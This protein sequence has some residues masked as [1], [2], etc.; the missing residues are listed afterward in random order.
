MK[1]QNCLILLVILIIC[2]FLI[3]GCVQKAEPVNC[4]DNNT[5]STCI[6]NTNEARVETARTGESSEYVCKIAECVKDTDCEN[7][8][9]QG[10]ACYKTDN[11]NS[12]NGWCAFG[13]NT[14][15]GITKDY[16]LGEID[17]ANYCDIDKDCTDVGGH[18][19]FGCNIFVNK[20]EAEGITNLMISYSQS[21]AIN[22]C[23][24]SP[25]AECINSKC[26]QSTQEPLSESRCNELCM[27]K[28][29]D[30]YGDCAYDSLDLNAERIG[31]CSSCSDCG[32]YCR[33]PVPT[34]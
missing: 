25:G 24:V 12:N 11:V 8:Y 9:G 29:G 14:Q 2:I 30:Y 19:P 3:D 31:S 13:L 7:K 23:G 20:L 33:L 28:G 4:H 6:C 1:E 10:Y 26:N 32:C 16:V 22:M 21:N 17:K 18:A 15:P 34:H 27:E 5:D